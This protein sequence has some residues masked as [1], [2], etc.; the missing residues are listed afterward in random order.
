MIFKEKSLYHQIHPLKLSTD[1]L[2]EIISLYFL[3]ARALWIGLTLHFIPPI[4]ASLLLMQYA[5]LEP[6]KNSRLGKYIRAHMSNSIQATR[7]AG[8][9]VMVVGAWDRS[10]TAI[11]AGFVIVLAAWMNGILRKQ[12]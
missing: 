6:Q 7:L 10:Q 12:Y 8:D 2:S 5:N 9:L 3:W 11:L 1:I 4:I